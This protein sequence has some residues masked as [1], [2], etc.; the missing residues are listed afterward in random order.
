MPFMSRRSD[1]KN[2]FMEK[3]AVFCDMVLLSCLFIATCL[4]VV[5][6]G[7]SAAAL[8]HAVTKVLTSGEGYLF[9]TYMKAWKENMKQGIVLTLFTIL[10]LGLSVG[11]IFLIGLLYRNGQAPEIL[12]YLRYFVLIPVILLLPWEFI[13]MSRF[14]DT[15]GTIVKNS[16]TLGIAAFGTTLFADL[17]IAI[18][19]LLAAFMAPALPFVITPICRLIAKKTE[20]VLQELTRNSSPSA[21][22]P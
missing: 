12:L 22:Q 7:A 13:Y 20:P 21:G 11:S 4:P 5:T 10:L 19:L 2:K 1:R 15:V 16:F 14:S 9:K 6:I 18:L 17:F 3:Y 8:Y